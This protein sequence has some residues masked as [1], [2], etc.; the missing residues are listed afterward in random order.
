MRHW[1]VNVSVE[2]LER[3]GLNCDVGAWWELFQ[4][5]ERDQL[6]RTLQV[7]CPWA[8][9]GLVVSEIAPLFNPEFPSQILET[10]MTIGLMSLLYW[11]S[12]RA[13]PRS[14]VAALLVATSIASGAYIGWACVASGNFF[15]AHTLAICVVLT[16]L[17]LGG[18][19]TRETILGTLGTVLSWFSVCRFGALG[20]WHEAVRHIHGPSGD[21]LTLRVGIHQGE[22]AVGAFGGARRVDYTALGTTVNLA[23]RL[24][25]LCPKGKILISAEVLNHVAGFEQPEKVMENLRVK[26]ISEPVTAFLLASKLSG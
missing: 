11:V 23:A 20:E 1:S 3:P 14:V 8:T 7:L 26:G 4:L 2:R 10:S 21:S 19:S 22:V 9:L 24:E 6:C 5:R 12:W 16:F 15:S 18:L 25:S 17:A 13:W